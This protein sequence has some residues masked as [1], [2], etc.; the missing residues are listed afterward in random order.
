MSKVPPL[1]F[2]VAGVVAWKKK[3]PATRVGG[4]KTVTVRI[5]EAK[6]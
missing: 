1:T 3:V 4:S 2:L 6:G 5:P